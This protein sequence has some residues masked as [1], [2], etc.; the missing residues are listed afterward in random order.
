[1][2]ELDWYWL[3][4]VRYEVAIA[5]Q[6][7]LR[8]RILAGD[9]SAAALILL[10]HDPVVTRG[11]SSNPTS[12][13]APADEFARRGVELVTSTRGG[14]V[15][16]HGPGQLM[17][18]PVLRLAA[19][20]SSHVETLA[21][22]LSD[23]AASF[24]IDGAEWRRDPAGLWVERSK[25]AACGLHVHHGVAIHGFAFNVATPPAAWQGIV[26]CGL[27]E[28]QVASLAELCAQRSLPPPP[29]VAA[30]AQRAAP[31]ICRAL[32]RQPVAR[33]CPFAG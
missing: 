26:P 9:E 12:L 27:H 21:R 29:S 7:G 19:G 33:V 20:V 24:G 31:I 32:E 30:L 8:D 2:A 22:A 11:R 1:M 23:L 16:Y 14:D 15:T 25:L 3:G 6:E 18:Y 10:E 28:M 17:V 13:T 4:R 5:I